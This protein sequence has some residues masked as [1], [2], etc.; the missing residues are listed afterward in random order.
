MMPTLTV[1][2]LIE[3]FYGAVVQTITPWT[4]KAPRISAPPSTAAS[5]TLGVNHDE[6]PCADLGQQVV[7]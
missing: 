2:N 7:A 5:A 6:L 1:L 3:L 4:P